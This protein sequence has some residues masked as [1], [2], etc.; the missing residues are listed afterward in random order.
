M[1]C[2]VDLAV[3]KRANIWSGGSRLLGL[4]V[5]AALAHF[6]VQTSKREHAEIKIN[7]IF[8]LHHGMP[9]VLVC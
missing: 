1:A 6:K 4:P 9:S 8:S 2:P 7:C 3:P 5:A